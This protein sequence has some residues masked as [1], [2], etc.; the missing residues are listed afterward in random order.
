MK[1]TISIIAAVEAKTFAIGKNNKLLYHI[2][3]DLHNFKRLTSGHDIIMGLNTFRSL[4]NGPLPNRTNIVLVE[5]I[6]N[7]DYENV[8]WATSIDEAIEKCT[9]P[10]HVFVIG[11][12]SVYKQMLN[13]AY[14]VYLTIITPEDGKYTTDADAF[15]P[16]K[17]FLNSFTDYPS[18]INP[19]K[20]FKFYFNDKNNR[21]FEYEFKHY[22]NK[23]EFT[24]ESETGKTENS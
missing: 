3:A 18:D 14:D 19:N 24:T 7:E 20:M 17:E 1:K 21:M 13:K 23:S 6:P 15:F 5:E 22:I 2:P 10:G 4:P 8:R 9:N 16:K 12:A 11:G